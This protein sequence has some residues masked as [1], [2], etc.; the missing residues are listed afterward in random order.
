MEGPT[1]VWLAMTL[2]A[3]ITLVPQIALLRLF[4]SRKSVWHPLDIL[5]VSLLVAQL[6]CTALTFGIS[7]AASLAE[8]VLPG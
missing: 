1:A 5:I 4:H 7:A 8:Y 3:P 6:C 2:A